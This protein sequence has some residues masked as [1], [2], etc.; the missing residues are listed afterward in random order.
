MI[1][2]VDYD[3]NSLNQPW[4]LEQNPSAHLPV[5]VAR[6]LVAPQSPRVPIRILNPG[7]E[8]I[9]LTKNTPVAILEFVDGLS[10]TP[11]NQVTFHEKVLLPQ[12][13]NIPSEKYSMLNNLVQKKTVDILISYSASNYWHCSCY[14]LISLLLIQMTLAVHNWHNIKFTQVIVHLFDNP[15][16]ECQQPA[17]KKHGNYYKIC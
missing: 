1:T 12:K 7:V 5:R 14:M 11:V 3:V 4:L 9:T 17:R 15:H 8:S 13:E 10:I 2:N 16:D 6:A